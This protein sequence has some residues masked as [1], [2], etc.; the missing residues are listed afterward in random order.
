M[1]KE[2]YM[3]EFKVITSSIVAT[4]YVVEAT[5]KEEAEDKFNDGDFKSCSELS[6]Y[7]I[8]SQEEI[9]EINKI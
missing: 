9:L 2:K 6:D 3:P 4:A 7:E 1:E 5:T 8:D